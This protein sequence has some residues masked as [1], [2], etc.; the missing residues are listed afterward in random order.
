MTEG[1]LIAFITGA[2]AIVGNVVVA[3][4]SNNKTIYRVEKLESKADEQAK[5][6]ESVHDTLNTIVTEV[7]VIKVNQENLTEETRKHNGVISRTFAL[8]SAVGILEEKQKVA[9]NR[10]KDMEELWKAKN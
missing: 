8:E 1:I 10:I 4:I 2:L 5:L 6:Y 7:S 3:V 9:N